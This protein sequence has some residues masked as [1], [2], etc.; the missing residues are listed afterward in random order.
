VP[1]V[2]RAAEPCAASL[3]PDSV[4]LGLSLGPGDLSLGVILAS[5]L[6]TGE[7]ARIFRKLILTKGYKRNSP[8]KAKVLVKSPD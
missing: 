8:Q 6:S 3:V 5:V 2:G 1:K 4:D 7:E